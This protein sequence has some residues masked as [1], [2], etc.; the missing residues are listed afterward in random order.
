MLYFSLI[1]PS[2]G[3][4]LRTRRRRIQKWEEEKTRSIKKRKENQG[5]GTLGALITRRQGKPRFL[6]RWSP[7]WK[8]GERERYRLG[9][10]VEL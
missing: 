3:E 9:S 4:G 6:F 8:E 10:K 1:V 2:G 5:R 7:A